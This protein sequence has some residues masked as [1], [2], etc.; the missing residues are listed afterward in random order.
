M[1]IGNNCKRNK[2]KEIARVKV[3]GKST[4]RAFIEIII[5]KI[6]FAN[7]QKNDIIKNKCC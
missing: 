2:T 3:R 1:L 4:N 5:Y 6:L 7:L